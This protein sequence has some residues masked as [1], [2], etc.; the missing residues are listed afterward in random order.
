ME[1]DKI[2]TLFKEFQPTMPLSDDKFMQELQRNMESVEIIRSQI[3]ASR[4]SGRRAA[5]VAAIV[6]FIAGI[7]TTGLMKLLAPYFQEWHPSFFSEFS[8]ELN[9]QV[10]GYIFIAAASTL[11][12]IA[13]YRTN[14]LYQ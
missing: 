14:P 6:G 3:V 10:V 9:K 12:A 13:A 5:F 7:V 8:W 1:E 2:I 11:S 4:R